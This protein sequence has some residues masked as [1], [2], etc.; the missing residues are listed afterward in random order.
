MFRRVTLPDNLFFR[1]MDTKQEQ[2]HHQVK[3]LLKV[4]KEENDALKKIIFALERKDTK[5]NNPTK[6]N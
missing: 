1:L 6:K 4:R 3:E 5:E 2:L